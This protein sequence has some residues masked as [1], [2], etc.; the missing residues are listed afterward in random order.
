MSNGE[1]S[2]NVLSEIPVVHWLM[3]K[4]WEFHHTMNTA[5]YI[6]IC[7]FA[8]WWIKL[9]LSIKLNVC[10]YNYAAIILI[11]TW[12]WIKSYCLTWLAS[13]RF[14]FSTNYIDW[15]FAMSNTW[16]IKVSNEFSVFF[17]QIGTCHRCHSFM[18]IDNGFVFKT[19]WKK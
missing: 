9:P 7:I 4:C 1:K 19:A 10:D 16:L 6:F 18:W 15:L 14:N 13:L 3:I 12:P 5:V 11:V 2:F 8:N 17:W